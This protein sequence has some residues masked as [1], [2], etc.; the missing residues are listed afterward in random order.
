MG[1]PAEDINIVSDLVSELQGLMSEN[2]SFRDVLKLMQTNTQNKWS[3]RSDLVW[4]PLCNKYFPDDVNNGE[5]EHSYLQEFKE[6]YQKAIDKSS[7]SH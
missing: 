3:Y 2:L 5:I 6:L 7:T 4:Q 1:K